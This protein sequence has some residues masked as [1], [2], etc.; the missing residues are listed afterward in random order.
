M[1]RVSNTV[2]GKVRML[3]RAFAGR[4]P[5]TTQPDSPIGPEQSAMPTSVS[6][7]AIAPDDPIVIYLR[8][9]SGA[10]DIRR[11]EI[12]SP[13]LRAMKEADVRIIVPLVSRGELIGLLKLGPRLSRQEYSADDR[14]L[15]NNLAA[16][17]TPA[18]RV[19]QLVRQQQAEARERQRIEHEM[20]VAGLIQQTLL[21]KSVP[22]VD[23]WHLA[24][25][26]RPARAVGGDFYDF[27]ELE[28]G[29]LGLVVGDVTDKGVPAALLMATTRS[30]LR[31]AA[32]QLT[33]PGAVLERVNDLLCPHI[34]ANMFVTCLYAVLDPL[35]G[36]VV[37]ANAG[38]DIPYQRSGDRLIELRARG[39][40]LG[41]M[42]AMHYEEQE[43][44]L[45]PG[46]VV[47]FYSDGLVEAHNAR[48]EMF[49]F[50][51]LREL[52]AHAVPTAGEVVDILL[53]QLAQFTGPG[54]EQEDDITLVTLQRAE[55]VPGR[56]W[57]TRQMLREKPGA[58]QD[59]EWETLITFELPSEPGN[60]WI[61]RQRVRAAIAP[62]HL[63]A[64]TFA[65]LET[66]V[67]EAAMNAMEHGNNYRPEVPVAIKVEASA[68]CI[69]VGITDQGAATPGIEPELPDLEL[70]LAG[71]QTPRGWGLFLIKN[72][73]DDL[74]VVDSAAGHTL[75]LIVRREEVDH[76][77]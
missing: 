56:R 57:P 34:P 11:L 50:S 18:V 25:H 31:S 13:A 3:R 12:D 70:K 1:E 10:V 59:A 65:R 17:A 42:A 63:A 68:D 35:T 53:E 30:I 24:A 37:Y 69:R 21:P 54:W 75:R 48:R 47:L 38:H 39:M 67:A 45:A 20:Q 4:R 71:R 72:M 29:R 8:E 19:A 26:Y 77:G 64:W 16:Q 2:I 55:P 15:L 60:E 51:R 40:P 6:A 23:G 7:L 22:N 52:V 32:T 46:D 49:G 73:V 44:L 74:Q 5:R 14:D 28:D 58:A 9:A 36:R 76:D 43:T 61:A 27:I 66:A 62:L 41:L 33:D